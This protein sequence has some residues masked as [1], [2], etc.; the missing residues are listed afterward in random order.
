MTIDT[1]I[2]TIAEHN[3]R[4]THQEQES[5]HQGEDPRECI[6]SKTFAVFLL[7]SLLR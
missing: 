4:H 6:S 1:A 5:Q 2:T 3:D 7:L